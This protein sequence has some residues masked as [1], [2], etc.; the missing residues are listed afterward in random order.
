MSVDKSA[1]KIQQLFHNFAFLTESA[2]NS[3]DISANTGLGIAFAHWVKK[4][5][6]WF[7]LHISWQSDRTIASLNR[8]YGIAPY[9]I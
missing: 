2:D 9:R 3:S 7:W 6:I 8:Q 5:I 4:D 1:S